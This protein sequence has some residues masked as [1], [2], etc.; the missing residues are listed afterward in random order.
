MHTYTLVLDYAGGTYISQHKATG[1]AEALEAWLVRLGDGA[2]AQD[3]S[4][5]VS[6]AFNQTSDRPVALEGLTNVWCVTAPAR[7]GLALVNVIQTAG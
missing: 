7:R 1:V 6:Q 3:I 5:E 2:T 4:D